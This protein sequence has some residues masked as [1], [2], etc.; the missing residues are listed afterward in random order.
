MQLGLAKFVDFEAKVV[1]NIIFFF[2]HLLTDF[3]VTRE[4]KE[5]I[6]TSSKPT[7]TP[8]GRNN[9]WPRWYRTWS[10]H[11]TSHDIQYLSQIAKCSDDVARFVWLSNGSWGFIVFKT[12]AGW[13]HWWKELTWPKQNESPTD[14]HLYLS[15]Q[16]E[17]REAKRF[18]AEMSSDS[19]LYVKSNAESEDLLWSGKVGRWSQGRG[20]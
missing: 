14:N 18:C 6:N 10:A 13:K 20:W 11:R 16:C 15:Q 17:A 9:T 8:R 2:Q 7:I 12:A 4:Q 5:L 19:L 1:R 3:R